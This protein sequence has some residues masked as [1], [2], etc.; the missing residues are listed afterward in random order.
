MLWWVEILSFSPKLLLTVELSSGVYI[1]TT[2]E[3][4]IFNRFWWCR[5]FQLFPNIPS[6]VQNKIISG[7]KTVLRKITC[8]QQHNHSTTAALKWHIWARNWLIWHFKWYSLHVVSHQFR[9]FKA[10]GHV[11]NSDAS[12][13]VSLLDEWLLIKVGVVATRGSRICPSGGWSWWPLPA[14]SSPGCPPW[15]SSRSGPP[16]AFSIWTV[17]TLWTTTSCQTPVTGK[18]ESSVWNGSRRMPWWLVF[19]PGSLENTHPYQR[20]LLG[21]LKISF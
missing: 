10:R 12:K 17:R 5:C 6:N 9:S 20:N 13:R 14:A 1:W 11:A 21:A 16:P 3:G 15:R 8:A 2:C 18:G 19:N 4:F 7:Y